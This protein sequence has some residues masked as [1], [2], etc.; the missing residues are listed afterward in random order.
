A[1]L[2]AHPERRGVVLDL[3]ANPGGYLD[4]AVDAAGAL[5]DGGPVVTYAR[6]GYPAR[7]L[8]AARGGDTVTPVVVLV[9]GGTASAAEAFAAALQDRGRAVVVGSRTYGKAAVQEPAPLSDGSSLQL[10]V[11]GYVTPAGRDLEGVG[12]EP[13][14][15]VPPGAPAA[16]AHRRA[17]DVLSG[18]MAGLDSRKWE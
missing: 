16:T 6:R 17:L 1:A 5:L 15:V 12:V 2:R 18:L 13:D 10:T 4:E 14:V 3:R 9:D 7:T 11:G 8:S